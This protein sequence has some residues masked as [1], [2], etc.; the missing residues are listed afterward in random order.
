MQFNKKGACKINSAGAF[1]LNRQ[2]TLSVFKLKTAF[3]NKKRRFP[4]G[5]R[6]CIAPHTPVWMVLYSKVG[7]DLSRKNF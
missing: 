2:P 6:P 3:K 7:I 5:K 4:D 1:A